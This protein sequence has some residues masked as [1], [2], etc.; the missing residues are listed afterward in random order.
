M[1]ELQID[2]STASITRIQALLFNA[3]TYTAGSIVSQ[4]ILTAALIYTARYLGAESFGQYASTYAL[5]AILAVFLSYGLD[6][7]L[8]REGVLHSQH[9]AELVG[10]LFVVK[11]V[12][13]VIWSSAVVLLMGFVASPSLP[14]EMM[15][16]SVFWAV[17]ESFSLAAYS[18]FRSMLRNT[19]SAG[20]QV[21]NS[22]LFLTVTVL[23]V[24]AHGALLDLAWARGI[25]AL[26]GASIAWTIVFKRIGLKLRWPPV[27][28]YV[29]RATPY[30][31]SDFFVALYLRGDV[32]II[33]L[34]VGS[35][36]AGIYA[37]AV[38]ILNTLFVVPNAIYVV[39]LPTLARLYAID[40]L[41]LRTMIWRMLVILGILGLTMAAGLA[42]FAQPIMVFLY[43]P[44]YSGSGAIL[45]ILSAILLFKIVSFGL[46]A[47]L[48]A[49]GWQSRRVT[50]QMISA[51]INIGLNV[52]LVQRYGVMAA[53][54]VYVI[55]ETILCCIYGLFVHRASRVRF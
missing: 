41:R 51:V 2:Q 30:M 7:Y 36:A 38:S 49:V 1:S 34:L 19:V 18:V 47:V 31:A 54:I 48:T 25:A 23:I 53:A 15:R 12:L 10:D 42:I 50:A 13:A 45:D 32:I 44:E 22:M 33:A 8:L 37:P 27:R 29:R 55:S 40:H 5:I 35:V 16:V 11:C 17:G 4:L 46:A 21:L 26:L 39:M 24:G 52:L 14:P 43:G 20:L 3:G 6:N 9:L 28:S